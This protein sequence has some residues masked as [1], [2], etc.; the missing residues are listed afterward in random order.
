MMDYDKGLAK[1]LGEIYERFYLCG[2][3]GLRSR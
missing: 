1:Q 2:P 3:E